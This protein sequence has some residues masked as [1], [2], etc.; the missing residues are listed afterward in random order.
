MAD[1]LKKLGS[2]TLTTGSVTLYTTPAAT[3][4][5]VKSIILCNYTASDAT[6]T[7]AFAGVNVIY[8]HTIAS[9]DTLTVQ[10]TGVL[11]A[12]TTITGLASAGTAITYYISGIEVN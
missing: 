10:I 8:T 7:I 6:V 5:I 9:Y 3:K 12:T 2:G 1:T 4:A 11:E